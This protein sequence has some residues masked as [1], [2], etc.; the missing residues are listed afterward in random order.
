MDCMFL[1]GSA[2]FSSS[3]MQQIWKELTNGITEDK[4]TMKGNH[5]AVS[6]KVTGRQTGDQLCSPR[7][8]EW[9]DVSV[10]SAIKLQEHKQCCLF[11][12]ITDL[13]SVDIFFNLRCVWGGV[14]FAACKTS[15]LI[16]LGM[17]YFVLFV[18][19]VLQHLKW[20]S[21]EKVYMTTIES[22]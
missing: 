22:K 10:C 9:W 5:D 16:P 15:L 18:C 4:T 8:A 11:V 17:I 3:E 13:S 7:G 12:N 21:K 2:G 6:A 1:Y 20:F 19:F 14:C